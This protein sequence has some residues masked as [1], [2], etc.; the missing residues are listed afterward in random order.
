MSSRRRFLAAATTGA[1]AATSGCLGFILGEESQTFEAS[2]ATVEES[3]VQQAGYESLGTTK[4]TLSQ[5]FEVGGEER[6]V[7]VVN[8]LAEYHRGVSLPDLGNAEAAVFTTFATPQVEVLG[9][10]LN[11]IDDLRIADLAR[12]AQGQYENFQVGEQVASATVQALGAARDLGQ[13]DGRAT[14][15]GAGIDINLH[16]ANFTHG[17][18]VLV[19]LGMYPK[20]LQA[21]TE[22]VLEMAAGLT[23]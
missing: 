22:N 3:V 20:Q 2:P 14:I 1:V 8:V 15:S 21:E 5:T 9:E 11:P 18:D 6:T 19:P 12:R 17:S 13:F 10:T 23:H 4:R 7:E 16:L